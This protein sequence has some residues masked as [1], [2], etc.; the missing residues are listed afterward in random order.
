MAANKF[1]ARVGERPLLA[2]TCHDC[3]ELKDVSEYFLERGIYY[4]AYCRACFGKRNNVRALEKNNLS[5]ESAR[6]HREPISDLD[7]RRFWSYL[8]EGLTREEIARRM[9]RTISAISHWTRVHKPPKTYT[10][11]PGTPIDTGFI[12][13]YLEEHL[14]DSA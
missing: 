2:K 10:A 14:A 3:R 5:L 13:S 12:R 6:R 8:E 4:S 11:R 1:A 9:G 7:K